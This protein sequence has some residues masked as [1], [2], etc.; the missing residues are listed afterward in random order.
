MELT[1]KNMALAIM[2]NLNLDDVDGEWMFHPTIGVG[3]SEG[4]FTGH[5][6]AVTLLSAM[7]VP[8]DMNVPPDYYGFGD[9]EWHATWSPGL[10]RRARR[11]YY[12]E[13]LRGEL[14][15]LL[16]KIKEII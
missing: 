9:G 3:N 7:E 2:K 10:Q 5:A 13:E 6:M 8:F 11:I 12:S 14:Q 4:M 15:K 16:E 1:A